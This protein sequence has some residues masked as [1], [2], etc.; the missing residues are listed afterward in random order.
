MR[1]TRTRLRPSYVSLSGMSPRS[2]SP[3]I[4]SR[5]PSPSSRSLLPPLA[6]FC[7]ED[8]NRYENADPRTRRC[9][10]HQRR[11]VSEA[12]LSFSDL[13]RAPR[14]SR[15]LIGRF[16]GLFNHTRTAPHRGRTGW[17]VLRS[18]RGRVE[19][20]PNFHGR[21]KSVLDVLR[22][23][24]FSFLNLWIFYLYH[25]DKIVKMLN[26]QILESYIISD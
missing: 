16:H 4:R 10:S 26:I 21:R 23:Q 13:S 18:I 19:T 17:V 5:F 8:V 25:R 24:V 12:F 9:T 20:T 6:V 3:R 11:T 2:L 22:D 1:G 15:R 7:N 14:Q